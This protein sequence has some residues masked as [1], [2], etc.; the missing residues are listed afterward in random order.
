MKNHYW[1]IDGNIAQ[2]NKTDGLGIMVSIIITREFGFNFGLD[3][4]ELNAKAAQFVYG[5]TEKPDL[6]ENPWYRDFEYGK[7]RNGFWDGNHTAIQLEDAVDMF[8]TL[9]SVEK[10]E[11][12][13][14]L[15]HSQAH[16]RFA[17]DAHVPKNFNMHPGGAVPFVRNIIVGQDSVG[18]YQHEDRIYPGSII[19]HTFSPNDKAPKSKPNMPQF[20]T[21]DKAKDH[22]IPAKELR[23]KLKEA[24]LR[25]Q[26]KQANGYDGQH[27]TTTQAK[28]NE[29]NSN[30][31]KKGN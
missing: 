29:N 3:A 31:K 1:T 14:E 5:K 27:N 17:D 21:Y 19:H 9:F 8:Y 6:T 22:D 25:P 4:E 15:D 2:R 26:P 10:Y 12:V 28:T 24:N 7:N 11:L 20:D 23:I 30:N 16:K 18:P 13:F